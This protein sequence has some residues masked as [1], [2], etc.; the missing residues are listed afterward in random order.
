M[1]SSNLLYSAVQFVFAALVILLGA[2]FIGLQHAPHLRF[3][4][5]DFF[6]HSTGHFS[7]IGY[8]ILGCGI[9]LLIGFLSMHRGVYY[10]LSMGQKETT[11][12]PAVIC[13]CVQSYWKQVFPG[14]DLSVQI[15]LSKEQKIEM[16][17]EFPLIST[18]KQLA[19]LERAEKDLSAILKK[20]LRYDKDFLLSVLIK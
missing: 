13:G 3:A 2:L 18:E 19:I 5:A 20:Q 12:D 1:K 15:G 7:L 17:V 8:L 6:A 4:I 14:D 11:I 9:L 10:R 16:F